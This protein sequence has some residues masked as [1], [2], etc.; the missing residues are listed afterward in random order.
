MSYLKNWRIHEGIL[1][2]NE[3]ASIDLYEKPGIRFP[4]WS[5]FFKIKV[6]GGQLR[7][8][9]SLTISLKAAHPDHKA[10][11]EKRLPVFQ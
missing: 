8:R 4:Y 1:T 11:T 7:S 9:P 3:N 6:R 2:R 5:H 10:G